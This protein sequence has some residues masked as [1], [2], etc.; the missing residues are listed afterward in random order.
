ME[1]FFIEISVVDPDPQSRSGS[2]RAKMTHK[3][4]NKFQRLL[5]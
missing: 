3:K 4:V 5:L 2:R 1:V